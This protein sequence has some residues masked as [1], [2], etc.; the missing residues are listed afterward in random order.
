MIFS[1]LNRTVDNYLFEVQEYVFATSNRNLTMKISNKTYTGDELDIS[2]EIRGLCQE[3]I[4]E[5][6]DC[7]WWEYE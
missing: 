3:E 7:Y 4:E 5:K 6:Y 1:G 2:D